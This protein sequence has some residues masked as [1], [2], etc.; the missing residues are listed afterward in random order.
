METETESGRA[1]CVA[2]AELKSQWI[3]SR[4]TLRTGKAESSIIETP[5]HVPTAAEP[6]RRGSVVL[7]STATDSRTVFD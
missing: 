5:P 4:S 6:F 3:A 2:A 7:P 1:K